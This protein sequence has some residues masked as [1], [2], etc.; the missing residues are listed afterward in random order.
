MKK[1]IQGILGVAA[2]IGTAA[3]MMGAAEPAAD[4][5]VWIAESSSNSNHV[6]TAIE[7]GNTVEHC[8]TTNAKTCSNE[9]FYCET[10]KEVLKNPQ[11]ERTG[12]PR[13]CCWYHY[14]YK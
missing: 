2:V 11:G 10:T 13:V 6:V 9:T 3:M 12:T 1:A 8:V 4:H 7:L 5:S 14:H